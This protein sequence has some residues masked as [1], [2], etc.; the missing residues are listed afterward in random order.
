MIFNRFS[1]WII[2]RIL[3]LILSIYLSVYAYFQSH[4]QV[5]FVF[6]LFLVVFQTF[7]L[8]KCVNTANIELQKFLNAME[9][10]DFSQKFNSRKLG[11]RFHELSESFNGVL[12]KLQ[13]ER[14]KNEQTLLSLKSLIEHV[15]VPLISI[16]ENGCV[17]Q[18]NNSARKLFAH[19]PIRRVEDFKH[20]S[21]S[22]FE[23]IQIL[24]LGQSSLLDIE[25]DLSV[26]HLS[27]SAIQITQA[28]QKETLFSLLDIQEEMDEIQLKAWQEL[29]KVLTHEIM[30]SITPI[31][32]IANSSVELVESIK[33]IV[34]FSEGV[35]KDQQQNQILIEH[36]DD[37][38]MAVGMLA[39]RSNSLKEFLKSYSRLTQLPKP[40]KQKVLVAE[41]IK[42]VALFFSQSCQ[43]TG[44]TLTQEVTP[45]N[46]YIFADSHMIEQVLLNLLKNASQAMEGIERPQITLRAYINARGRSVIEVSDN[47][48]G[49]PQAIRTKIFIPF[50]TSKPKGTGIGLA[51]SKQIMHAHKGNIILANG[52]KTKFFLLF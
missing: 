42:R 47:G 30:N 21:Q 41:L 48:I 2:T 27:V 36:F 7:E 43:E 44:I 33:R 38:E 51:L 46:L 50:Y 29:V 11:G 4:L 39:S 3:L 23:K 28:N 9:G 17:K 25:I 15:P 34:L 8:I 24:P 37:M 35:N 12:N 1:Q 6:G 31:T 32:S 49:I 18:W 45:N 14:K 20:Y 5:T 52:G 13:L 22:F 26:R 16:S 10:V 19:N 40:N